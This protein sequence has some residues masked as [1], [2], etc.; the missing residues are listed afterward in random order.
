MVKEFTFSK[1][2][3]LIK[4]HSSAAHPGF[5]R[6]GC[7]TYCTLLISWTVTYGANLELF[8]NPKKWPKLRLSMVDGFPWS[9]CLILQVQPSVWFQ[10]DIL[11]AWLLSMPFGKM[12]TFKKINLRIHVLKTSPFPHTFRKANVQHREK[13]ATWKI[14]QVCKFLISMVRKSPK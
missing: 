1:K 12:H 11:T 3:S 2:S 14:I 6:F 9:V 7:L 5:C 13:S 10:T 8:I 4:H